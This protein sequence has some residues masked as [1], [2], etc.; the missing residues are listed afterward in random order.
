MSFRSRL[1]LFFVAIVLVPMI[2]VGVL[3]FVL[4][5][6]NETGKTDARLA[7]AQAVARG[8]YRQA[9]GDAAAALR[10]VAADTQLTVALRSGDAVA[11]RARAATLLRTLHLRRLKATANGRTLTDSGDPSA[12]APARTQLLAP[13][14]GAVGRLEVSTTGARDY[15]D[16]VQQV[17]TLDA[18][19]QE[20]GRAL[21][22]TGKRPS[23][24][25]PGVGTVKAGGTDFRVA[26]FSA[27]GFEVAPVRV[28]VLY[29]NARTASSVS[30]SRLIVTGVLA[31]FLVLAFLFAIAV[32]RALQGQIERFLQA[33]RRLG[34]GDFSTAVPTEGRDEFAELGA[35]FNKMSQQLEARLEELRQERARL[36]GSIRRIGETFASN[37]DREALLEIVVDTALDGL[38]ADCGRASVRDREG[39]LHQRVGRGDLAAFAEPVQAAESAALSSGRGEEGTVDGRSALAVPLVEAESP[40]SVIGVVTVARASRRFSGAERD[41][42]G[43]L[44][45]QASVSLENVDLH[46]L[47]ARQA[48]TDELT[49]LFNHR[50]F[51]EVV[52]AE[53]GRS[54]RFD[55]D[56]GLLMLDLDDFKEINDTYGH[57][58]GDVVLREVADV[59]R[60]SSRE[61]DEPA[62][63][64]GEELAVALPQTDLDGAF[65]LAERVREGVEALE[66]PRLDGRGVLKVTASLGVA[67]LPDCAASK[68]ELISAADAALYEA[69]HA[70]KNRTERAPVRSP[71]TVPAD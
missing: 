14:G 26:S 44:A 28:S 49:G 62:R 32:S 30:R 41:L 16:R 55:Q 46:E 70:G 61:I 45:R 1:T 37:L 18:V 27:P 39:R 19:L 25:L 67:A 53:V 43:Y 23:H 69:K 64:G 13:G 54:K 4:I 58:Q 36:Q 15:A 63:Y 22:A 17:T 9:V 52:D 38:A 35:E 8:V 20:G 24:P 11:A 21:A 42:F 40:G 10:R 29:D 31:G 33:A 51:Q 7:E 71:K 59:L 2:S 3:V 47:V 57:Q 6:D 65:N 66:I 68:E 60:D 12:I 50:R 56:L 48:V 34:G 5:A